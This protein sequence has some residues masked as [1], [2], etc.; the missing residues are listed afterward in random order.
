[1]VGKGNPEPS[2]AF[3]SGH[4]RTLTTEHLVWPLTAESSQLAFSRAVAW[5]CHKAHETRAGSKRKP[6]A[7]GTQCSSDPDPP[8]APHSN[9]CRR[10]LLP[11]HLGG[12]PCPQPG[13]ISTGAF[14]TPQLMSKLLIRQMMGRLSCTEGSHLQ[15]HSSGLSQADSWASTHRHPWQNTQSSWC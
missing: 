9:K 4:K 11:L 2:R 14:L 15:C 6:G 10:S 8:P 13:Q 12:T 7:W 3:E 5:D 1:M